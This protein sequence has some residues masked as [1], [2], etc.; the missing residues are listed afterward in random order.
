M[1]LRA[2][3]KHQDTRMQAAAKAEKDYQADKSKD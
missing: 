2:A 1:S 3:A